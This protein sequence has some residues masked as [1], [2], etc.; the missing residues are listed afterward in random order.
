MSTLSGL[1]T[2]AVFPVLVGPLQTLLALLP[3]I[4]LGAGSMVFAIF[5]PGGFTKLLRFLWRQKLLLA[6]VVGIVYAWQSG[7]PARLI[8]GQSSRI[9]P[10]Q[11]ATGTNWDCDRGGSHR[12]GRGPG[13]ADATS[14]GLVW[15]NLRDK[16]V[17]SS[18]AVSGNRV[19]YSTATDIGPFSPQGRGA[20]VCV[21]AGT[22][23]EVWRYAPDNYRATFSSPV[24]SGNN[25]VCGE[26][27]HQVDDARV[28]CL[29]ARTGKRRWEFRTRSH[30][31]STAAIDGERVFI[32]AGSDGFYCLAIDPD[33]AGQAQ[34][35]WHLESKEF[36]DCESS[37]AVG[38][39]VVYFGLGEGGNAICGVKA[40]SGEPLWKLS[41]P[42]PVF[43]SPTLADGKLFVA[44]G[45][46]NYVQSAADLLA[47]KLQLLRDDGAS[48]TELAAA[49][50]RLKPVGEVWCID[51]AT[52]EMAWKFTTS[53]AILGSIS[54]GDTA[55]EAIYFG[56]RDGN[57]YRV[58]TTG[59]L[60]SRHHLNEPIVTSP[61]L[62]WQHIYCST[63]SGRLYCLDRTSLKPVWDSS[64]GT[65]TL[66]SSSPTLAHGHVYIGTAQNGLRCIGH[67]GETRPPMWTNGE[68]GGSTDDTPVAEGLE[69]LW[70]YPD[71][72]SSSFMATAPL[73]PLGRAVYVAGTRDGRSELLKLDPIPVES[74]QRRVWSRHFEG[75]ITVAP[76]GCG[77]RICVIE[78]SVNSAKLHLRCLSA[79]DGQD[80]WSHAV[81]SPSNSDQDNHNSKRLS[82]DHRA[83]YAWNV[84]GCLSCFDL[85]TG[86]PR[87]IQNRQRHNAEGF[88]TPAPCDDVIFALSN[89][90]VIADE[91]LVGQKGSSSATRLLP[92]LSAI[93]SL[94]GV[95]L[96]QVALPEP[97][98]GSPQTDGQELLISHQQHIG[99]YS[100]IDGTLLR[101]QSLSDTPLAS[102]PTTM[103]LGQPMTPVISIKGRVLYATDRGRIVC[104]GVT[105][106]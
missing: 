70:Q 92:R 105:S 1:P 45:N 30:V 65:G 96:W 42:Y 10:A 55:D 8:G 5:R 59:Q 78:T 36:P 31:E 19:Y 87:W 101:R 7:F 93:D 73:M 24:V 80:L 91:T 18:V 79:V 4:L 56:S 69:L 23:K 90:R 53:D 16:T 6:T 104:L 86:D 83:V 28:T 103:D 85:K 72:D 3:A 15:S 77:E 62:G 26:G 89:L 82:L 17:L 71:A 44:T 94:T 14:Q 106:P 52:Q 67:P 43:G 97:P 76:I 22:G 41:T 100:M 9:T 29:D 35:L 20:I 38:D 2:I 51:L 33:S 98:L 47:M 63:T 58:S 102:L 27:L 84:D 13:D 54:C 66:F 11:T 32:G 21:D 61:A 48:E 64:L 88:A 37:P 46:G 81:P 25:L 68:R 39:G 50:E 40:E 74:A 49:R 60:L 34:V 95:E 57:I 75:A 12:L 99:V